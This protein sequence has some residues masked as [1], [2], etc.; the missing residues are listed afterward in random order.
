VLVNN[1][2]IHY[3]I[4]QHAS[5]ADLRIAR[6]AFETNLLGAPLSSTVTS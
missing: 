3:D 6:E 2:A 1:A 4:H 5:A